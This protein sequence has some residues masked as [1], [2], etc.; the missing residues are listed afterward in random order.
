[1]AEFS[2]DKD[3]NHEILSRRER[4]K[5]AHRQDI[6]DAATRVFA[7]K[8]FFNATLDEIAQE[9]EFSKGALYLYFNNKEDLLYT[10]MKEKT[11]KIDE[12]VE[13]IL[14]EGIP[15]KEE[16]RLF[17][18][19]L[20]SFSFSDKEFLQIFIVQHAAFFRSLSPDKAREFCSAHEEHDQKVINRIDGAIKQGE[21]RNLDSR[22]IYG[23]IHGASE[24]MM[25]S[26]WECTTEQDLYSKID[27]FIDMLFNGIARKKEVGSEQ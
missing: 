2:L 25:F 1:M 21:L 14:N 9:A 13:E 23:M 6:L 20:A 26:R 17:L 4:E 24:N 5:L 11:S 10:I 8:G 22:S 12:F 7:K 3:Q 18:Q 27:I 16:L 19:K 15:F